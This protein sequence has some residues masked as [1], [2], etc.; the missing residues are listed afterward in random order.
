M[1]IQILDEMN[2]E[3][4]PEEEDIQNLYNLISIKEKI[5]ALTSRKFKTYTISRAK[6]V[7]CVWITVKV[8]LHELDYDR[9]LSALQL[10]GKMITNGQFHTLEIEP[11]KPLTLTKSSWDLKAL[12]KLRAF[13]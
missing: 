9:E 5:L 13:M 8:T 6:H 2:M 10:K 1:R 12:E 4:T 7:V 11:E 3:I